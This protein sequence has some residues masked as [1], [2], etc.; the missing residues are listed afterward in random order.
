MNFLIFS[1]TPKFNYI[2]KVG[3]WGMYINITQACFRDN[4]VSGIPWPLC[5]GTVPWSEYPTPVIKAED[6]VDLDIW[7]RAAPHTPSGAGFKLLIVDYYI[8]GN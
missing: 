2:I 6:M 8:N 7:F 3:I 1:C 4:C 5:S